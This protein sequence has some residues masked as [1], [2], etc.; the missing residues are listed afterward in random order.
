MLGMFISIRYINTFFVFYFQTQI[1]PRLKLHQYVVVQRLNPH[2]QIYNNGS[3]NNGSI[4][5]IFHILHL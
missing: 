2:I 3:V 5:G 4:V 1:H